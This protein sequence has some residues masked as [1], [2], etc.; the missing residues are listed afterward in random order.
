MDGNG[1]VGLFFTTAVNQLTPPGS[2]GIVGGFFFER[3]LFPVVGTTQVP[4]SCQTSNEGEMF[5]LPVVDPN[6]QF[7][8]FFKSKDTLQREIIGTLAHEFQHLINASRRMYVT[9]AEVDFEVVWLNE[10]MSHLAEELLFYR[11]T[12]LAPKQDINFATA[13]SPPARLQAVNDYQVDNLSRYH[14]YLGATDVNSPF[15]LN[16]SLTTRGATWNLLRWALDQSPSPAST[17]M[18]ALVDSDKWGQPNFN[19]VFAGL[20]GLLG[21]TRLEVIANF[22]DNSGIPIASQYAFPSWNFRDL[23]PHLGSPPL[24]PF[25]LKTKALLPGSPQTYSLVGGGSGYLRFRVNGGATAGISTSSSGAALPS[26]IELILV[27]TQ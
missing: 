18:R 4:F 24:Q 9:V 27:R 11:I 14:D 17:Y 22:F 15:A 5:Y 7:N 21:A 25:P 23:L 26:T 2:Q 8:A 12:G 16:D 13:V 3:D 20:G 1:R 10:G 6:A 19:Q